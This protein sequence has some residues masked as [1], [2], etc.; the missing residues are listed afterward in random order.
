[1][2][3]NVTANTVAG[4]Y[5]VSAFV[6]GVLTPAVFNL[7]NTAGPVRTIGFLQQP[8]DTLPV[9]L[10]PPVTVRVRDFYNNPLPAPRLTSRSRTP[11]RRTPDHRQFR[12]SYLRES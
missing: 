11:G 1:M 6:F 2:D 3:I 7:T 10:S 12:R 5:T 8:T 4:S 9:Q